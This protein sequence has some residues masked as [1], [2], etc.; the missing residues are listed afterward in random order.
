MRRYELELPV[1]LNA[2]QVAEKGRELASVTLRAAKVESKMEEVKE[3]A[4][5]EVKALKEKL[6]DIRGE[7]KSLARSVRKMEVVQPVMVEARV[8]DDNSKVDVV[9]LDTEEVVETRALTE[10]DRQMEID[11]VLAR[12][13]H[14]TKLAERETI[15]DVELLTIA[16]EGDDDYEE[17]DPFGRSG[18]DEADVESADDTDDKSG[19]GNDTDDTDDSDA[20]EGDLGEKAS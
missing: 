19:E 2:E 9:R 13:E 11:E 20:A 7:V 5:A 8:F 6:S 17:L 12:I 1:T 4:R 18:G 16:E 10:A 15:D 14:D 3:T